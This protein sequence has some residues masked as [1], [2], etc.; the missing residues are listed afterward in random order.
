MDHRIVGH[1]HDEVIIECEKGTTV[2][3][4]TK[5]MSKTPPWIPGLILNADGYECDFYKKD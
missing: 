4:I 3:D 1:V 5:K 2:S